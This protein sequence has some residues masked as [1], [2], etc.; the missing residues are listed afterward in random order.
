M[1]HT[2]HFQSTTRTT[3]WAGTRRKTVSRNLILSYVRFLFCF[4][5]NF[6]FDAQSMM[7]NV[8]LTEYKTKKLREY[9][10]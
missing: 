6:F 7:I 10:M 3:I 8:D 4:L 9:V 2:H 5:K 1:I